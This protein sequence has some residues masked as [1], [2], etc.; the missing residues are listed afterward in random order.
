MREGGRDEEFRSER[1]DIETASVFP[2][3]SPQNTSVLL[4]MGVT[5]KPWKK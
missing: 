4:L 2:M 3:R 1:Q 5:I